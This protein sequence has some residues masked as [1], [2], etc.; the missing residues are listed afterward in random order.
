MAFGVATVTTNRLKTMLADRLA[1]SSGG[2][3]S[4]GIVGGVS[5]GSSPKFAAMGSGATSASRTASSSDQGLSLEL[6]TRATG[7]WTLAQ[8]SSGGPTSD[9]AVNVATITATSSGTIDE[10][11]LNDTSSSGSGYAD[12]SAT[13]GVINLNANDSIQWTTKVT[14][15]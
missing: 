11:S 13:L 7:A 1:S 3:S 15:T 14:L 10:F 5:L 4:S 8:S 9:T 6:Y 2:A 12:V